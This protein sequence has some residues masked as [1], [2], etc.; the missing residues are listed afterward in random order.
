MHPPIF[1][2]CPVLDAIA[3]MPAFIIVFIPELHGNLVVHEAEELLLQ[4]VLLLSGPLPLEECLDLVVTLQKFIAVSP[5]RIISVRE[6]YSFRI[7]RVPKILRLL[8]LFLCRL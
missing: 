6:N 1:R 4:L 3:P 5:G 8:D 7:A 2:E